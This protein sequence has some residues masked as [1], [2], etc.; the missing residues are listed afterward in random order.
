MW[1]GHRR[2]LLFFPLRDSLFTS[3]P[4]RSNP[5]FGTHSKEKFLTLAGTLRNIG[6]NARDVPPCLL[7][8]RVMK[9]A[10]LHNSRP[11]GHSDLPD[12]SF[13][14]YDAPETIRAVAEALRGLRVEVES[15]E[16][17]RDLPRR[18]EAG[19]YAFAF[20]IAEGC[21]RRCREAI[22]AAV[23][24]LLGIPFTG[25]DMLTLAV[26]LDKAAA[27]RMVSPEVPVA[28]AVLIDHQRDEARLETLAYPVIVKPNDE[29]SSK[30]IRNNPVART[31][32]AAVDRARWLRECYH[33]PVLVEEFLE[34]T[35]V[36][37]GV[38]GNGDA[39]RVLGMMEIA[40]TI[41]EAD[42]TYSLEVKRDWRRCVRYHV[43][44]RLSPATI[45]QL[46]NYALTAY[47]LLGCR[48]L[49]RLDFRL[50]AAGAP[51]FLECNPL[52]GLNPESGDL[53]LLSQSKLP[54]EILVQGVLVD[55]ARRCNVALPNG[56]A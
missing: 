23:C 20:N 19:G 42:W 16:A 26:T 22:P 11:P 51:H 52:P 53:V 30:G 40:P 32:Q 44:P 21:G 17:D 43:P 54:Y 41:P 8:L 48:D 7:G 9:V 10:L 3:A 5:T 56:H 13:E 14:E 35:E 24:E 37:V 39:V 6:I 4:L 29:G 25:S 1:E 55:A 31:V 46:E 33:C 34:G 47:G 45:A 12:D 50:D 28:R 27:R 36:T 15:V 49:A 2:H 38:A 18:L